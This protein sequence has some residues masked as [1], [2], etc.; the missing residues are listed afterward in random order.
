M[1]FGWQSFWIKVSDSCLIHV[2]G[3]IK[4]GNIVSTNSSKQFFFD[5]KLK[6]SNLF[7]HFIISKATFSSESYNNI[8]KSCKQYCQSTSCP[9]V[10]PR[11]GMPLIIS[12]YTKITNHC[13]LILL[14]TWSPSYLDRLLPDWLDRQLRI[15]DLGILRWGLGFKREHVR[16]WSSF[17]LRY[18]LG[19]RLWSFSTYHTHNHN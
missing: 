17:Q 4:K 1:F 9:T 3:C 14:L 2:L 19:V 12:F 18:L 8:V 6:S 11:Y 5:N 13:I 16:G 7:M 15:Y 10:S